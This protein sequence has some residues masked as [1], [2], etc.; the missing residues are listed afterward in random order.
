MHDISLI[1]QAVNSASTKPLVREVLNAFNGGAFRAALISLWVAVAVDLTNK[2]R[3]L[4]ESGDGSAKSSIQKLD[5][6]VLSKDI[7]SFL[8]F[9]S[10][11]IDLA[12]KELELLSAQ[13]AIHLRRL[14]EDRNLCAHP[15]FDTDTSLF[16]PSAEAI[17]AHLVAAHRATFSRGA[18]AG[19][20]RLDLLVSEINGDAWPLYESLDDYLAARFFDGA[21]E[22][23]SGNMLKLLIKSSIIPPTGVTSPNG[24]ARRAREAAVS[25]RRIEPPGFQKALAAVLVAWEHAGKLD[26]EALIRSVGAYGHCAEFWLELP[27]TALERARSFIPRAD[28]DELVESRFF[29]RGDLYHAE[30]RAVYE[31]AINELSASQVASVAKQTRDRAQFVDRILD[32]IG[33]SDDFAIAAQNMQLL[34]VVSASLTAEHI[35][36]LEQK[37]VDNPGD[38]IRPARDVEEALIEAFDKSNSSDASLQKAWAD[39][40]STLV[41]STS[42]SRYYGNRRSAPYSS[43]QAIVSRERDEPL[44]DM[45]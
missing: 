7:K 17:R 24:V 9:E 33:A 43:L 3:D 21:S 29:V 4:A 8:A 32:L 1:P 28:I 34:T 42:D 12:E 6:A 31:A 11:L 27:N 23:T 20:R 14:Y 10:S 25:R 36:T 19:K 5:N 18:I 35:R 30:I 2:V 37:I 26:N 16:E 39:L 15:A 38:Q 45:H 40:A 22:S 44:A 13:E 41:G